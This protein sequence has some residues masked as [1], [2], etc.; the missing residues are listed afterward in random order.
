MEMAPSFTPNMS[1]KTAD[2]GRRGKRGISL[3][4]TLLVA[5][6]FEEAVD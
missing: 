4:G 3:P 5:E 6:A 1:T 2:Q